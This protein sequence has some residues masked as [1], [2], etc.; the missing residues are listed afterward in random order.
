MRHW[1]QKADY[2]SI[3]YEGTVPREVTLAAKWVEIQPKAEQQLQKANS[4]FP[5]MKEAGGVIPASVLVQ[6]IQTTAKDNQQEFLPVNNVVALIRQSTQFTLRGWFD[7]VPADVMQWPDP[8]HVEFA[9][10]SFD[11]PEDV[12]RFVEMYGFGAGMIHEPPKKITGLGDLHATSRFEADYGFDDPRKQAPRKLA[13]TVERLKRDQEFLRR[14]WGK[15]AQAKP[16]TQHFLWSPDDISFASGKPRIVISDIW[17]Y[18]LVLLL[19]D[20]S[21]GRLKVCANPGCSQLKY[22]AEG[23]RDQKFCSTKCKNEFHIHLW[24]A[25]PENRDRWNADRRKSTRAK[26]SPGRKT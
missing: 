26:A 19:I 11:S 24:L 5:N 15:T 8:P 23:R 2:T 12:K 9:N 4:E 6:A 20:L 21:A 18:I 16:L 3:A 13:I 25:N 22:F 17:D 7:S 14:Y 10:C 1:T